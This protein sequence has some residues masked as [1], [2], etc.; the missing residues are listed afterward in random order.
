[1]LHLQTRHRLQYTP[2]MPG[3]TSKT[4]L[5]STTRASTDFFELPLEIRN[6]IYKRVLAVPE[7][8]HIFQDTDCPLESFPPRKPYAWLSLLYTNHRIS[9]ESKIV[10]YRSNRFALEEL[11]TRRPQGSLLKSFLECIGPA[12]SGSLSHLCVNFPAVEELDG[13]SRELRI[14]EDSL[15]ALHLLRDG[16]TGLNTLETLVYRKTCGSFMKEDQGGIN[17]REVLSEINVLLSGIGS[18]NRIIVRVCS[19]SLAPSAREFM[20]SLGWVVLDS[21]R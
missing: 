3:P 12:N 20:R 2:A 6:D 14:R 17:F 10:L 18:L 5:Q 19:G 1:M 9:D 11:E 4:P 16:C 13:Q 21:D 15:Q 7:T 8:L